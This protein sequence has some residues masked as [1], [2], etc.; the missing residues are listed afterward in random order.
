MKTWWLVLSILFCLPS[1]LPAQTL[2]DVLAAYYQANGGLEKMKTVRSL[3]IKGKMILPDTAMKMDMTLWMQSPNQLRSELR[4]QEQ[5]GVQAYDGRTAWWIMP[6][7]DIR[8]P[9]T[10]P[11]DRAQS[12]R[13]QAEFAD[14]LVS[15]RENG[16]Q[17]ELAGADTLAETPV[18]KLK[19][20]RSDGRIAFFWLDASSGLLVKTTTT[21]KSGPAPTQLEILFSDFRPVQ[22]LNRP[23]KLEIKADGKTKSQIIITAWEINPKIS[24]TLFCMPVAKNEP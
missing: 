24:D 10:M 20:T 18:N 23:F 11:A 22:N 14:P 12:I 21:D 16:W 8:T 2:N 15:F 7:M 5:M 9:Q 13:N 6:F 4:Y 3:K 1:A 17:L 19:L